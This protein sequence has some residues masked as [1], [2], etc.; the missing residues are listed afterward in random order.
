MFKKAPKL[1]KPGQVDEKMR[2]IWREKYSRMR[3]KRVL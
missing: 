2:N 3:W 1:I